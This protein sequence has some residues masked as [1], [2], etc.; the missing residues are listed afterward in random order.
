MHYLSGYEGKINFN[1]GIENYENLTSEGDFTHS[2]YNIYSLPLMEEFFR[3]HGFRKF[4]YKEF[5]IDIDLKKQITKIWVL[6][7]L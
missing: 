4:K 6:I 3:K 1:I 5:E 7:L 2:W